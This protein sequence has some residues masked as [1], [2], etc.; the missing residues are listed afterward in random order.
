MSNQDKNEGKKGNRGR[1]GRDERYEW[2]I[3]EKRLRFVD[4]RRIDDNRNEQGLTPYEQEVKEKLASVPSPYDELVRIEDEE[5]LE[6]KEQA[7]KE[8]MAALVSNARFTPRQRECYELLYVEKISEE[9]VEEQLGI[10]QSRL[11]HYKKEIEEVLVKTYQKSLNP[12]RAK[13]RRRRSSQRP[14]TSHQ[15]EILRP[16]SKSLS[17]L[18]CQKILLIGFIGRALKNTK[19]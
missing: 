7:L 4:F 17:G 12:Q 3:P 1:K 11:A 19:T 14:L 16:L 5:E 15:K 10:T 18:V 8:K 6:L 2:D 9:K 13:R